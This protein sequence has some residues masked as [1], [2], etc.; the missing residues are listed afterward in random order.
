MDE[1]VRIHEAVVSAA[2]GSLGIRDA[3]LLDA[4]VHA[5]QSS[6]GGEFLYPGLFD[7][8]AVY[9]LH[10]AANHAFV[11]GNKR[12]AW[13]AARTFLVLNGYR[14]KPKWRAVVSMVESIGNGRTRSWKEIS[15]WLAS[16]AEP[17]R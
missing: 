10:I 4:A 13:V 15:S 12:T 1:V 14:A 11:D 9:L 7:M 16:H 8:A 6:Y 3:G 2:G 17:R 5:P